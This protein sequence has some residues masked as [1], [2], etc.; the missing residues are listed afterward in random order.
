MRKGSPHLVRDLNRSAVLRLI[1]REG[2][3]A[4]AEI[5]RRLRLSPATVT[6]VTRRMIAAGLV[7]VV[8]Q[9]P[10]R[11][12][13]PALLLGLVGGAANALGVKVAS[14]HLVGVRVDLDAEVVERFE[15][16][17]QAD[18]PDALDRLADLLRPYTEPRVDSPLFLGVGLG[19]PG[20]VDGG[21]HKTVDSPMLGWRSLAVGEILETR[22]GVPVLV[23]ND[24]NTLAVAGRL[25]GRG[26][27][28]DH[29][30]TVT[31]GRG[32]GLGIIV[33]GDLYRGAHG[34]AGEFGHIAVVEDGPL[35]ECGKHGCLEALVADPALVARG[36]R[37][38]LLEPGETVHRLREL[39]EAGDLRAARI[40]ADAGS[41]L[42]RAVA[43]LVNVL[44]P[45]LVLISGEGT[46]A[47]PQLSASFHRGL[48]EAVFPPLGSVPVEIDPWDDGKW[49]LG[50][51]ALV[52]RATFVTP[53]DERSSDHS[54]RARLEPLAAG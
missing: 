27:D 41:I 16:P 19:V 5:A 1:G 39:A 40:F 38:G 23:D 49:A 6:A 9:A 46:Q 42:G 2:P 28:V 3:I 13:R 52:L 17:F 30:L 32:V 45:E 25:Y 51:A 37:E 22:L 10:S 43:G 21:D 14:D 26:K 7:K 15:H 48:T 8:D 31:I 54:V 34:G 11:G 47:W 53:L 20:V 12:G 24:V 50:A 33:G 18:H 4:R 44:S 29:F 35:C 36:E